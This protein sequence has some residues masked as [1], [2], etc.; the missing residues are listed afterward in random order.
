MDTHTLVP[1]SALADLLPD[2]LDPVVSRPLTLHAGHAYAAAWPFFRPS[3]ASTGLA[4][5]PGLAQPNPLPTRALVLVRDDGLLS[6]PTTPGDALVRLVTLPPLP[7]D[8]LWTPDSLRAYCQG[9]HRPDPAAVFAALT[10]VFDTFLDFTGS[11]APQA[12]VCEFLAAYVLATW[13]LPAFTDFPHLWIVGDTGAGKTRLLHLLARLSHLGLVLPPSAPLPALRD[14]AALGAALAV[15]NAD[16]L[17]ASLITQLGF[18]PGA[19]TQRQALFLA[20]ARRDILFPL[21]LRAPGSA[22]YALTHLDVFGP[23]LFAAQQPPHLAATP[24]ALLLPLLRSNDRARTRADPSDPAA[25]P[26]HPRALLNDLWALTLAR[27][28]ELPA[29]VA[30]VTARTDLVGA[31]F[32]TWYPLLAVGHWLAAHGL[33]DL[34]PRLCAL[35][36]AYPQR[37]AQ[38]A[39][40]PPDPTRLILHGLYAHAGIQINGLVDLHHNVNRPT[41]TRADRDDLSDTRDDRENVRETRGE[42]E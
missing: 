5:P 2:P 26:V 18:R 25:W 24:R 7:A 9:G 41:A 27:L 8:R 16:G 34:D 28:P 31:D 3:P 22:A 38:L 23:R 12:E 32:Q 40:Q 14:L 21:R 29:H 10:A 19:A 17:F 35:T 30:A 36:A 11:L 37:L 1:G 15:D 33:P 20:G 4:Q 39:P 13:F 42:S 6:L